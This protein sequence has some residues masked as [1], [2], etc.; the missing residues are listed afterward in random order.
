MAHFARQLFDFYFFIS[1]I[2]N[3]YKVGYGLCGA[4]IYAG[5][6]I[7]CDFRSRNGPASRQTLRAESLPS[8]CGSHVAAVMKRGVDSAEAKGGEERRAAS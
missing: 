5:I 3:E 2:H 6:T 1:R 8:I 7:Y 4:Y